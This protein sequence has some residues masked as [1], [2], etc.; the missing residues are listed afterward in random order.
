[1]AKVIEIEDIEEARSRG[2]GVGLLEIRDL[3]P[4]DSS[5]SRCFPR[6]NHVKGAVHY[7]VGWGSAFAASSS[8]RYKPEHHSFPTAHSF[9][10]QA[11]ERRTD[12]RS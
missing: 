2:M 7:H 1:M 5:S 4:G 6:D 9:R 11:L 8:L 12:F 3:K 10:T